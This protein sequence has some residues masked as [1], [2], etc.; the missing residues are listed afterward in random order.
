MT[1]LTVQGTY[2][3]PIHIWNGRA[4]QYD[5]IRHEEIPIKFRLTLK[6]GKCSFSF[7][8]YGSLTDDV[9]VSDQG[10][11]H[12]GRFQVEDISV[13]FRED[14]YTLRVEGQ[15][16]LY[17]SVFPQVTLTLFG[18]SDQMIDLY[19]R[20]LHKRHSADKSHQMLG[21]GILLYSDEETQQKISDFVLEV[22]QNIPM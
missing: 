18:G 11:K 5:V 14:R 16:M 9:P 17:Q 6:E 21:Q 13:R 4:G 22:S 1:T 8:S 10:V 12:I 2:N 15:R 19:V 20:W 3:L 7:I